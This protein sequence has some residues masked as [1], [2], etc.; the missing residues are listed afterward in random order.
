[1]VA[2]DVSGWLGV[3]ELV[4]AANPFT[5]PRRMHPPLARVPACVWVLLAA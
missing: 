5:M 2:I 1:L 4:I 3:S